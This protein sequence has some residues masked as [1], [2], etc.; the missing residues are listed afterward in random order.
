MHIP[1]THL[2]DRNIWFWE[3]CFHSSAGALGREATR[4]SVGHKH[5]ATFDE[6]GLMH[7]QIYD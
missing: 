2:C 3:L 5:K 7:L 4:S 6:L 1:R